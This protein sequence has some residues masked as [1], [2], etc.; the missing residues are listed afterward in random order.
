MT[1]PP[2]DPTDDVLCEHGH[3]MDIHCCGCRRRGFF[4]PEDGCDCYGTKL[5]CEGGKHRWRKDYDSGDTCQCGA[6]YLIERQ[7]G[8]IEIEA[9]E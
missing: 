2:A 3:A 5:V 1:P 4:P 8:T 6:F 9:N 7:D